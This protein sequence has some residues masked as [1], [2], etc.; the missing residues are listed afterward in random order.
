MPLECVANVSEGRDTAVL[1]ALAVA[2][3][4]ALLDVHTDP[5]HHRSV[6]TMAGAPDLVEDAARRLARACVARIDVSRHEGVHPRL[7]ALDVVPFVALDP[8]PP[9]VAVGAA[10]RFAGWLEEALRVP[11][12]LYGDADPGGRSLPDVRRQ[13]SDRPHPTAGT[14]AVGARPLL[15]A[16]NCDLATPDVEVARA[17]AT[18]VRGRDGGLPGVRALGFFLASRDRAQVSMNLVDLEATGM[19]AACE[20]VRAE[21]GARGTDVARVELVGLLPA[22]ELDRCSEEFRARAGLDTSVT[23]EARLA[24]RETAF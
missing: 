19:E 9:D 14:T 23:I 22:A 4:P 17:V 21:A 18:A 12:L 13:G 15:V 6:L 8:T 1:D 3:G 20:A 24:A 10:R 7:G 5:D 2:C 16:V 11:P